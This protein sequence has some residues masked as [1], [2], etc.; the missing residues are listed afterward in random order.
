M[1]PES[2]RIDG[3]VKRGRERFFSFCAQRGHVSTEEMVAMF[4]PGEEG[5]E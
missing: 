5:S 2:N 4:K 1:G 3:L